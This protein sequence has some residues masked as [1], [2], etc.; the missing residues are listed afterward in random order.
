M[1]KHRNDL[2][3]FAIA[4]LSEF[5]LPI[6]SHFSPSTLTISAFDSFD[7]VDKNT[8][9]GK[10]GSHDTAITLFQKIPTNKVMKPKRSEI[11]VAVVKTLSKLAC[12]GLV[13]FSLDKTLTLQ[14]TFIV[15]TE[16][17]NPNE[18]KKIDNQLKKF[19]W[20]CLGGNSNTTEIDLPSWAGT[21]ALFLESELPEMHVAFL[22]FLPNP[23]TEVATV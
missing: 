3:K 10:S 23:V 15:E 17:Y 2:P 18:K 6:S 20:S 9:S 14:K 21:Q 12:Q 13:P 22:P 19:F 8:L 11:S 16:S 4:N 1:K 7:H 5:G